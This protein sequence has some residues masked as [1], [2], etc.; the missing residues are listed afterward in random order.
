MARP[1]PRRST[2]RRLSCSRVRRR[3]RHGQALGARD[4]RAARSAA[5]A[6]PAAAIRQLRGP[7]RDTSHC[8]CGPTRMPA[9]FGWESCK[10]GG[11]YKH[12]QSKVSDLQVWCLRGAPRQRSKHNEPPWDDRMLVRRRP[13]T[14]PSSRAQQAGCTH[15]WLPPPS[16]SVSPQVRRL[17]AALEAESTGLTAAPFIL[18]RCRLTP[19]HRVV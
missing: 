13:P 5:R 7:W 6:S 9:G 17:A 2:G 4:V 16:Q 10:K 11:W 14:P 15:L 19:S 18:R 8:H 3:G 1:P 12:V